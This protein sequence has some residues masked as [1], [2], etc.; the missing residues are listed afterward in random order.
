MPASLPSYA[1]G[2]DLWEL[3]HGRALKR[4]S[5]LGEQSV[6]ETEKINC[7]SVQLA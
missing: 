2:R 4:L 7:S 6:R 5:D 1:T 3:N